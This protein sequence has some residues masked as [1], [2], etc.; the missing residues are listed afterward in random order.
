MS[1]MMTKL[2]IGHWLLN[3]PFLGPFTYLYIFTFF[4][5][6]YLSHQV[7]YETLS[8]SPA[9]K[10]WDQWHENI[11]PTTWWNAVYVKPSVSSAAD[12]EWLPA[13]FHVCFWTM[14]QEG[15]ANDLSSSQINRPKCHRRNGGEKEPRR[16]ESVRKCDGQR[17]K[18]SARIKK[19]EWVY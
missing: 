2:V 1:L 15:S 4:C 7:P 14:W 12:L 5:A 9:T 11:A 8:L 17:W 19:M 13:A 18:K 3:A 10:S 16:K 6:S